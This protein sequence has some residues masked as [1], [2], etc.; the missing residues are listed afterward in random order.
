[1]TTTGDTPLDVGALIE[2]VFEEIGA[3]PVSISISG[4]PEPIESVVFWASSNHPFY[5]NEQEA[6]AELKE[7]EPMYRVRVQRVEGTG[8]DQGR[9]KI[10]I[11]LQKGQTLMELWAVP[12]QEAYIHEERARQFLQPGQSMYTIDVNRIE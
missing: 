5:A 10:P 4:F 12:G 8:K 7:G 1:M 6:R 9:M 11:M 3:K 2:S